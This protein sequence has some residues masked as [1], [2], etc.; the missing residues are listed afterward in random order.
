MLNYILKRVGLMF[1]TF[2][3]SI[4]LYFMFIKLIPD[5]HVPPL[6]SDDE[7]YQNVVE[8]EGWNKPIPVQF[9]YWIRNIV[10]EGSFGWSK[11][12]SEDVSIVYFS[13]VPATVRVNVIPYL[14]SI[15]LAIFIGLAAALHKNKILDHIISIGIIVFIS[16]PTFVTYVVAQ[17]VFYFQ[18]RWVPDFKVATNSEIAQFGMWYGI[19]TY[20]LPIVL[21]TIV[22]IPGSARTVRAELTEQLTQD[23]ILLAQAKGMTRKQATYRHALKNALA[24][25]LPGMIIGII[26]VVSGSVVFEQIFRING[27][28]GVF[29]KAFQSRDYAMIML[30]TVFTQFIGLTA[31][32]LSD[33]TLTVF[34]PRV[35]VG[36]GK[37]SE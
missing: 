26:G 19:G 6:G 8:K 31:A 1:I 21:M 17:Y 25:F 15:P 35:R 18:L 14:V 22:S 10:T 16:V 12:Y 7:H 20:I 5:N 34:D 28:G 36:S 27:T 13:R 29:L 30:G 3:I 11:D 4:F 32:I 9:V 33:I 2:F 23:Y 24:P 37:T